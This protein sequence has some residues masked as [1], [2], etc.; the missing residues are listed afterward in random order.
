MLK[1]CILDWKHRLCI[2]ITES[3][4]LKTH[5]KVLQ[6]LSL[7]FLFLA[8]HDQMTSVIFEGF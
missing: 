6:K 7:L 1:C 5:K 8:L 2:P 4:L 3:L